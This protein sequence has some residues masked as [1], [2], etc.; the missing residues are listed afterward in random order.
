MNK[1]I[2]KF[3][4]VFAVMAICF[5]SL[6]A[7]AG[8]NCLDVRDYGYHRYSARTYTALESTMLLGTDGVYDKYFIAVLDC[9]YKKTDICVCGE[10]RVTRYTVRE[11]RKIYF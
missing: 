3:F 1:K 4:A 6:G 10:P 5:Q 11:K 7:V 9:T 2:K 8:S